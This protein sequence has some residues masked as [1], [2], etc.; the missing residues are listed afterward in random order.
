MVNRYLENLSKANR[1]VALLT[2]AE[3]NE[4]AFEDERWGGGHGAFTY[5]LLE[6]MRGNADISPQDG[7]VTVGELFEY[8]RENVQKATGN[9]QHPSVGTSN[10]DRNLPMAITGGI[11]AQEY[12]RLGC[13]LFDL[14]LM[15]DDNRRLDSANKQFYEAIRL[16]KLDSN[17]FPECNIQLGK[18]LMKTDNNVEAIEVFRQG[19][20]DVKKYSKVA[21]IPSEVYLYMGMAYAKIRNYSDAIESLNIFLRQSDNDDNADWIR[22]YV[23]L[24][25]HPNEDLNL[26]TG[27]KYALLIGIQ[28]Y[29][30][31]EHPR[32]RRSYE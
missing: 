24:L 22:K 15:L 13:H 20:D 2:S 4:V 25:K 9:L 8:V 17:P 26:R 29:F 28:D 5:F 11:T 10:Y 14:G 3:A 18:S 31:I 7:I 19:I 16:S 27:K 32:S 30:F 23:E 6:G 12:F 1:G 21:R